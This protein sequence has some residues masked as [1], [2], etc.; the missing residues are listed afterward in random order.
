MTPNA[1]ADNDTLNT[2]MDINSEFQ[3]LRQYLE[4]IV[5]HQPRLLERL[6]IA[7]LTGWHILLEGHLV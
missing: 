7:L 5:A 1:A 6:T 3:G 2:Q 4:R